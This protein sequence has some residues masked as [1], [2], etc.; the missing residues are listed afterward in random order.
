MNMLCGW[1][2]LAQPPCGSASNGHTMA[3][4]RCGEEFEGGQAAFPHTVLTA[5]PA[6]LAAL[7]CLFLE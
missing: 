3:A 1:E 5:P 6:L 7:L 2:Q 4:G